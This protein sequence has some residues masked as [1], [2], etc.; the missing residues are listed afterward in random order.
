MNE[1]IDDSSPAPCSIPWVNHDFDE[2][3]PVCVKCGDSMSLRPECRWSDN[4]ALNLCHDCAIDV[5]E[6]LMESNK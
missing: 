4:Q 2:D 5:V 6:S 3:D 1:R